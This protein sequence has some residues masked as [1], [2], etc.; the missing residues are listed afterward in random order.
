MVSN[1]NVKIFQEYKLSKQAM[2]LVN[3]A[4]KKWMHW[5]QLNNSKEY[6][7]YV[8]E[9]FT[10][11]LAHTRSSILYSVSWMHHLNL[12]IHYYAE[13]S[14]QRAFE[15]IDHMKYSFS[16]H[17]SWKINSSQKGIHCKAYVVEEQRWQVSAAKDVRMIFPQ[18]PD[19][20]P[21]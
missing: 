20:G 5:S 7:Y 6:S 13:Q 16:R 1:E 19:V 21:V 12:S 9:H 3:K 8:N 15:E 2:R 10:E 18:K 17:A 4:T 14:I 11:V